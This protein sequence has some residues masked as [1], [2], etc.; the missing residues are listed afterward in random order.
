MR[1]M[2]NLPPPPFCFVFVC[3]F[4]FF[5]LFPVEILESGYCY[6]RREM[7]RERIEDRSGILQREFRLQNPDQVAYIRTDDQVFHILILYIKIKIKMQKI[8]VHIHLCAFLSLQ[9]L[10]PCRKEQ[11]L[12]KR[13]CENAHL[14]A[15]AGRSV[16]FL[17]NIV[18]KTTSDAFSRSWFVCF[19]IW[20]HLN[21]S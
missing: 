3:L 10:L 7:E 21:Y 11:S 18:I 9:L 4:V 1:P 20:T 2:V 12:K 8:L 5:P 6:K 15:R 19:K 13:S 14:R 17:S 16:T